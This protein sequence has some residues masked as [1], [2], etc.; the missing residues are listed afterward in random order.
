[1]PLAGFAGGLLIGL[2]A[3]MMLL[4]LGR[5]AGVSGLAAR[6]IGLG[7]GAP[8]PIAAMFVVGLPLGAGIV[9][10]IAGGTPVHFPTAVVPLV[11]G[12]LLVGFGTRLGSGC[13]SGHGVCG[14]SRFSPRSLAA[15][16]SFM[17]AGFFTVAVVRLMEA[18]L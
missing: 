10:R 12:G 5:I 16:I 2:A 7:N 17:L 3:A 4:G 8:W 18:G 1:M 9:S 15:T 6:A 14:L 11:I 13:T